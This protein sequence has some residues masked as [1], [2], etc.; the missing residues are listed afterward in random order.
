MFEYPLDGSIDVK[1][2]EAVSDRP[3]CRQSA[4]LF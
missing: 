1:H 3:A 2:R 4:K